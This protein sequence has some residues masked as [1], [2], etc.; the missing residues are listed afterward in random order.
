LGSSHTFMIICVAGIPT[1]RYELC[2]IILC[3]LQNNC[4][5]S[6]L[7]H[8]GFLLSRNMLHLNLTKYRVIRN[9]CRGFNNLS[10][11]IHLR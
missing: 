6:Y 2:Q 1:I 4:S 11:T 3:N 7:T 9:D 10:H 5:M 8:D